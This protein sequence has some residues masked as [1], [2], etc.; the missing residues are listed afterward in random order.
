LVDTRKKW[1]LWSI[2][3][4][5]CLLY[6]V[7]GYL[8]WLT[9]SQENS[10]SWG[11]GSLAPSVAFAFITLIFPVAGFLI[12]TRR[13]GNA[14]AWLLLAIGIAWGLDAIAS[15]Y[16]TYALRMH[17]GSHRAGLVAASFDNVLWLPAIGLTG[18]FLVLLFPDGHLLGPRWRWLAWLAATTIGLGSVAI[19]LDPGRMTGSSFPAA[20]NP[21]GIEA[22]GGILAWFRAA[23][24]LLPMTILASAI[25]LILRY[26]RA[27]GH[28]RLQMKWLVTAAGVVAGIFGVVEI[29]SVL[30]EGPS[31]S[32][33]VWLQTL[34]AVA[35]ISFGLIPT[36][37]GVAVLRHR[38]YDIDVIIRRTLTYTCVAAVLGTLY[39]GGVAVLSAAFQTLVGESGGLA[40]TLSTLAAAA[41]FR[42]LHRHTQRT[43]DRRFSRVAY[44]AA[45]TLEQF[46]GRLREQIDLDTLTGEVLTV[47][48][49]TVQPSH[50]SLW[51]S[52]PR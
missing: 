13:P 46:S 31:N 25:S 49:D 23:V 3:A 39:L 7:G 6:L 17:H 41:A 12:A 4:V 29:A 43:V 5:I 1:F 10:G 15:S 34:Q 38:L 35:L 44:D 51:L 52:P 47:V 8:G 16:A 9:R 22:L 50:A 27:R 28:E 14:I 33:P 45:R 36:S 2:F 48:T 32:I 30:L 19:L 18:V 40:V 26:R 42:P 37:I 20:V 21:L 24:I 11:T